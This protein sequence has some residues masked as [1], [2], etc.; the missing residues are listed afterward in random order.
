MDFKWLALLSF[1]VHLWPKLNVIYHKLSDEYRRKRRLG[2]QNRSAGFIL[3]CC[4]PSGQQVVPTFC[5]PKQ[6]ISVSTSLPSEN[7]PS[8]IYSLGTHSGSLPP[9]SGDIHNPVSRQLVDTPP[10]LSSV[11]TPPVSVITTLNMVGLIKQSEIELE[12]VQDIQFLG[13]RLHLESFTPNIQSSGN[14]STRIQNIVPENFVV[15]RSVQIH[16]ITQFFLRS[17]PTGLS[18]FEAPTTTFPFV[19]NDKPVYTPPC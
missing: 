3:S 12:P 18:T 13:L 7:C 5:L 10:R 19:W 16:G 15:Y 6:G 9:L 1:V 11:F 14:N 4:N 17:H 8:G 2:I